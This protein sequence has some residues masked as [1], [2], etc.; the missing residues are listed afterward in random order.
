MLESL[1]CH[2]KEG[3][4][5][6]ELVIAIVII[7]LAITGVIAFFPTSHRAT[8]DSALKNR[9]ANSIVSKVEEL[10]GIG[11][12]SLKDLIKEEKDGITLYTD[13]KLYSYVYVTEQK[14][15]ILSPEDSTPI[16]QEV[17]DTLKIFAWET[18]LEKIVSNPVGTIEIRKVYEVDNLL[19]VRVKVSWGDGRSYE[20]FTYIAP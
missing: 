4:T 14:K 3:F 17:D 15:F 12:K 20:I 1:K 16:P 6:V 13:N 5:L 8:E 19:S 7:A 10:K 9:I 18:E 2:H 11:Y